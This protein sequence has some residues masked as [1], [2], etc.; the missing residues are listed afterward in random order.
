MTAD[1][2]SPGI[3]ARRLFRALADERWLDAV[4]LVDPAVVRKH[5][6]WWVQHLAAHKRQ[7]EVDVS[8]FAGELPNR[9][10]AQQSRPRIVRLMTKRAGV[11]PG[12]GEPIGVE[13]LADLERLTPAEVMARAAS[14]RHAEWVRR[15][16]A[17][18]AATDA[19][20]PPAVESDRSSFV[21][22]LNVAIGETQEFD[23]LAHVL[24]RR[25]LQRGDRTHLLDPIG[26][27]SFRRTPDGWRAVT[28]DELGLGYLISAP[29]AQRSQVRF[30][31][32]RFAR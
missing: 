16:S 6:E 2:E 8:S 30:Q 14:F 21:C 3:V 12:S 24:Y 10:E 5:F 15:V 32:L 22:L 4:A 11:P 13:S 1:T 31:C 28:L 26:V 20:S 17:R 25:L 29:G 9:E 19:D 18:T 7:A 27:L 23:D